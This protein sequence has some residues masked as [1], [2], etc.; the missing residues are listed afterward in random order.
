MAGQ[1]SAVRALPA[2]AGRGCMLVYNINFH[3]VFRL[4]PS[5][6]LAWSSCRQVRVGDAL[7]HRGSAASWTERAYTALS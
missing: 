1:S 5:K 6:P 2:F 3:S 4:S 7:L